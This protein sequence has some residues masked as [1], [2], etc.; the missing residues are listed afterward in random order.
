MPSSTPLEECRAP[1][2][3]K[4]A[5]HFSQLST[6]KASFWHVP[7]LRSRYFFEW[8]WRGRGE[9][10][11]TVEKSGTVPGVQKLENTCFRHLTLP[12][13]MAQRDWGPSSS[14]SLLLSS[15]E[16]SD[17]QDYEPLIRALLGTAS[18]FWE[19]GVLKRSL[20]RANWHI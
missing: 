8:V 18:H 15:L 14:P 9:E 5:Y 13:Q 20:C 12:R 1:E 6:N 11:R 3:H 17:T 16:L 10:L 4:Q 2:G 7:V 19:V